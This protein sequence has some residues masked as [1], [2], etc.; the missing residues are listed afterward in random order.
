[1]T[2]ILILG[3]S[4]AI[5]FI[6]RA[7]FSPSAL[8]WKLSGIW[9]NQSDT[10]QIMMHEDETHLYGHVVSAAIKGD[11][12]IVI[13]KPVLEN[14]KLRMLWTW[15]TGKYIDPYT[16]KEFDVKIKLKG[17]KKLEVMLLE[18]NNPVTKE[19]WTLVNSL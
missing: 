3:L 15:S 1:M 10:L 17:S 12:N 11:D 7:A 16:M 2:S 13:G 4:A 6:V 19:E 9:K 14:V 5:L 18:N 8:G